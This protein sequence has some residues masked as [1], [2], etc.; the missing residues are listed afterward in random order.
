MNTTSE[1]GRKITQSLG[2]KVLL[3]AS[4]IIIALTTLLTV[5]DVLDEYQRAGQDERKSLTKLYENYQDD[6]RDLESEAGAIAISIADRADLKQLLISG[7]KEGMYA[8]LSPVFSELKA[9]ANIVHLYVEK[10]DGTVFVRIHNPS[11]FG[12]SILYRQTAASVLNTKQTVAGVEIGPNRLGVR[13]V[14]PLFNGDEF[15]GMVE[16]GLDFDKSFVERLR[17]HTGADYNI[18]VTHSAAAVAGLKPQQDAFISPSSELFYY[19]G[20]LP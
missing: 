9:N 1:P 19:T 15:I 16:V 4:L 17:D 5:A 10:P 6:V 3:S 2:F 18:W 14:A 7:D 12:D 13:G 8:L 20:T 11:Q